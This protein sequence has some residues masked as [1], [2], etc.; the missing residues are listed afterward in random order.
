M[1]LKGAKVYAYTGRT[2]G[3]LGCNIAQAGIIID[4]DNYGIPLS[5]FQSEEFVLG[6]DDLEGQ[7]ASWDNDSSRF[8]ERTVKLLRC[9]MIQK[10]INRSDFPAPVLMGGEG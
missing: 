7:C 8:K 2:V 3:G 9:R 4:V 5:L 10:E 1:L 6:G